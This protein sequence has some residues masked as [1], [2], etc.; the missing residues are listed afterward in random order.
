MLLILLKILDPLVLL[1]YHAG[2]WIAS[3]FNRSCEYYSIISLRF[4]HAQKNVHLCTFFCASIGLLGLTMV[5][6]CV[7]IN[8]HTFWHS[9]RP[10]DQ[11]SM[12]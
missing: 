3:A 7:H 5:Q 2:M 9:I 10:E 6:F 8:S 12:A 1:L 11:K 4:E